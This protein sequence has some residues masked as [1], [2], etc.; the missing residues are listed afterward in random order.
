MA[1]YIDIDA[2]SDDYIQSFTANANTYLIVRKILRSVPTADVQ[3]VKRGKWVQD[4]EH[5]RLIDDYDEIPYVKCSLCGQVE[6]YIDK[7]RDTTPN[8]C[9]NCGASMRGDAE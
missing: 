1:R 9:P 6:W 8:Y 4:W 2:V 5:Q 3:E 7:E